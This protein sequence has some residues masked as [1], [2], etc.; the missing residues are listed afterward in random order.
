MTDRGPLTL[1]RLTRAERERILER[2][3]Q[4]QELDRL[5][6][7]RGRMR[8]PD[9]ALPLPNRQEAPHGADQR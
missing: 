8:P 9:P 5:V 4:L 2:L 6:R 1:A 3:G 7:E